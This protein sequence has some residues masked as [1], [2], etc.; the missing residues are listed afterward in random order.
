MRPLKGLSLDAYDKASNIK[1]RVQWQS[2]HGL[3]L[4]VSILVSFALYFFRDLIY[5]WTERT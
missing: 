4:V 5:F 1:P 2:R 3:I